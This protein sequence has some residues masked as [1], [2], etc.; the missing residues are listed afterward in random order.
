M[1][2]H[3]LRVEK[4]IVNLEINQIIL[5]RFE[6]EREGYESPRPHLARSMTKIC[7]FVGQKCQKT[8]KPLKLLVPNAPKGY[9]AVSKHRN[10]EKCQKLKKLPKHFW[11]P[12]ALKSHLG[13]SNDQNLHFLCAKHAKN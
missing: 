11:V 10:L 8:T 7:I 1:M 4:D 12:N 2:V 3:I 13:V 9:L 6:I 5:L